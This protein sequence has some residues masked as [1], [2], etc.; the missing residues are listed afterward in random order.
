MIIEYRSLTINENCYIIA[1]SF[2]CS[3]LQYNNI[4]IVLFYN[5]TTRTKIDFW[6]IIVFNENCYTTEIAE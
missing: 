2:Y 4:F 3:L 6:Y 5:I 1:K